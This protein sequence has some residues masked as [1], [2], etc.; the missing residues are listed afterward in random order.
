MRTKPLILTMACAVLV[1]AAYLSVRGTFQGETTSPPKIV[2]RQSEPGTGFMCVFPSNQCIG[3][4][5][6]DHEKYYAHCVDVTGRIVS[7]MD[8]GPLRVPVLTAGASRD[9]SVFCFIAKEKPLVI[10]MKRRKTYRPALGGMEHAMPTPYERPPDTPALCPCGMHLL[11][12]GRVR[13]AGKVHYA[14]WV[15]DSR[16]GKTLRQVL[17]RPSARDSFRCYVWNNDCTLTWLDES[18]G[19]LRDEKKGVV[20]SAC[21][22]LILNLSADGGISLSPDASKVAVYDPATPGRLDVTV[23]NT[24]NG[25][26]VYRSR[27]RIGSLESIR[28]VYWSPDSS[29]L[30]VGLSSSRNALW[31]TDQC[32]VIMPDGAMKRVCLPGWRFSGFCGDMAWLNDSKNLVFLLSSSDGKQHA[33]GLVDVDKARC[34]RHFEG[35]SSDSGSASS[36]VTHI[37]RRAPSRGDDH[38]TTHRET[39]VP[40]GLDRAD[41]PEDVCLYR[42]R[43]QR[44]AWA[45]TERVPVLERLGL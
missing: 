20:S 28:G 4:L 32:Y 30:C 25:K 36:N 3:V 6:Y 37:S 40:E 34:E 16:S 21:R 31:L 41:H 27:R 13:E 33:M 2:W 8:V 5:G 39:G 14:S 42:L 44:S 22:Q 15:V 17:D 29:K 23:Y 45:D 24:A 11:V 9:E 10:D 43:G 35:A 18:T 7:S 26:K 12:H 1:T 38:T 19:L